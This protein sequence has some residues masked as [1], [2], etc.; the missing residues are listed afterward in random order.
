MAKER[1]S[2]T[3]QFQTKFDPRLQRIG[4]IIFAILVIFLIGAGVSG[5]STLV[6]T[7][8]IIFVIGIIILSFVAIKWRK[9]HP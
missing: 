5:N 7:A 2:S 9:K 1:G 8:F 3:R 6:L 4:G